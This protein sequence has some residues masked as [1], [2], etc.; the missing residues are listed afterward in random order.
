NG[1]SDLFKLLLTLILYGIFFAFVGV[2]AWVRLAGPRSPMRVK[3]LSPDRFHETYP[4]R[5]GSWPSEPLYRKIWRGADMILYW[6]S[7]VTVII[8]V[9]AVIQTIAALLASWEPLEATERS[10]PPSKRP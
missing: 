7:L 3:R 9:T 1:A 2:F 8:P 6:V 4:L 10:K 5:V